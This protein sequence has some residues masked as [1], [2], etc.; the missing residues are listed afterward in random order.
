MTKVLYF[1][2]FAFT[3]FQLPLAVF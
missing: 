1:L 3:F 2:C